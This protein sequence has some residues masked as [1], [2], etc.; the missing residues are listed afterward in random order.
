MPFDAAGFDGRGRPPPDCDP[1][2]ELSLFLHKLVLF[3]VWAAF[4]GVMLVFAA[5]VVGVA[6]GGSPDCVVH[7][8]S[9]ACR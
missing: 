7:V 4:F 9:L 1:W 8:P 3:L 5:Y 2:G 6:T